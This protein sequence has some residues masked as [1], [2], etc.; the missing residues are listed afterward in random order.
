VAIDAAEPPQTPAH[1]Y[2]SYV[3]T[4]EDRRRWDL[5]RAIAIQIFGDSAADVWQ[6]TRALYQADMPTE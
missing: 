3:V 6:A 5:A 1:E 4:E 2:P